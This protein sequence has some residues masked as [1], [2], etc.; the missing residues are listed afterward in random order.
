MPGSATSGRDRRG[1]L[2]P[3]QFHFCHHAS[4]A[5]RKAPTYFSSAVS[6][7]HLT[8]IPALASKNHLHGMPALISKKHQAIYY[9]LLQAQIPHMTRPMLVQTTNAT[10]ARSML[11]TTSVCNRKRRLPMG[12]TRR[13]PAPAAYKTAAPAT[14]SSASQTVSS[15]CSDL[16]VCPGPPAP[17]SLLQSCDTLLEDCIR[18]MQHAPIRF[19][20]PK[21]LHQLEIYI[22]FNVCPRAYIM[23]NVY[24]RAYIRVYI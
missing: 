17:F 2:A 10:K 20:L 16:R 23:Y 22:G 19:S 14:S 18:R 7:K 15:R 5:I 9:K 13:A 12:I 8:S 6:K 4:A 11:P 3:H 21:L 1:T 24:P